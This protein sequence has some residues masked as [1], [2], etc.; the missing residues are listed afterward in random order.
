MINHFNLPNYIIDSILVRGAGKVTYKAKRISDGLVVA[1]ETVDALY[2]DR[3]LVASLRR[4]AS[5]SQ[6]LE[7]IDGVRKIHQVVSYGSGNI[8]LIGDL[9]DNSLAQLIIKHTGRTLPLSTALN[10]VYSVVETLNQVHRQ[11]IVHKALIPE[12]IFL[13]ETGDVALTGFNIASELDQERQTPQLS[14]QLVS[15]FPYMSPEQTGRMNRD[16]DYRSDYYSLGVLFYELLTGQ[17][18]FKANDTLGWVYNHVCH[19]PKSPQKLLPE[20][21]EV[22]ATIVMKLLEKS[23]EKRYQ[24]GFGLLHDIKCCVEQLNTKKSIAMFA[25]GEFDE[26]QKFLVPQKLYGREKESEQLLDLFEQVADG[27]T[28][29]CLVHGYSGVGKS[30]LV[31]E[32]DRYQVRERGF[33]VQSKFEQFQ[34]NEPYSALA[35]TYRALVQQ[36][37]SLPEHKLPYWRDK[38]LNALSPSASLLTAFV[39]ELELIIGKQPRVA[40]LP[41]DAARNRLHLTLA[42]FLIALAGEGHPVVLFLDDLHWS[43]IPTL[44]LLKR[45][46][47]SNKQ[48]HLLLIGAYRSNEVAAGHPLNNLLEELDKQQNIV[49]IPLRPLTFESV[50]QLV[51]D[52]LCCEVKKTLDL[53]ELLFNKAKGNPFFTNELLRQLHKQGVI[54]ATEGAR[55]WSYNIDAINWDNVS[56]NIIGFMLDNLRKLPSTSQEVLKLASCIGN[57]FDL[58]TLATIYQH[59]LADTAKVLL[60]ALKQYTVQPLHSDY[61]LVGDDQETTAFNPTYRFQHDKVQQ[62][63]YELIDESLLSQ[64]HLSIGQL[65]IANSGAVVPDKSISEIVGHLNK[66]HTLIQL[67]SERTSLAELN[68]RAAKRAIKGTAYDAGLKYLLA[69]KSLLPVKPWQ[70]MPEFMET[71]SSELQQ[72]YYHTG[73]FSSAELLIDKM[74]AHARS[75]IYR[76]NILA[77]RT[78]QYATVGRMEDSIIAAIQG[79]ALLNIQFTEQPTQADIDRERQDVLDNLAERK[80]VDLV[81]ADEVTEPDILIAM[82]LVMEIFPAAFLSGSGNLFPY[83]VLK[84]VNLSLRYGNCPESAFS[85]AAYGML[86]CGDLDEPALGYQYG[87]LALAINEKLDDLTLRS[88]VFYVYAMFIHHWS[89]HWSTLTPLFQKGIDAGYQSGDLL[90]LAYSAQDLVIWDPTLSLET[91]EYLHAKNLEIVRE[92]SYQ[93]S[94]DSGTLFL[95]LQR[96]FLGLTKSSLSLDDENFDGQACLAGMEQRQFLTG[97]AN[98]NIYNAEICFFYGDLQQA[99]SFVK[100]QD[101]LIKSAMSLPQLVR[102]YL[103]AN[104][105]LTTHY[106]NMDSDEQAETMQRL[107]IDLARMTR[108]AQNCESNFKHLEYLMS[109]E[110]ARIDGKVEQALGMYDLA[111]DFARKHEFLHDEAL[112]CERAACHLLTQGKER[113]AEGYLRA[114]YRLYDRRGAKRKVNWLLDT[115]P[116]LRELI[117]GNNTNDKE[118]ELLD[119]DLASVMKASRDISGEIV[120]DKLL[121]RSMSILLENS[122]AQWGCFIAKRNDDFIVEAL[123]MHEENKKLMV[124]PEHM[125]LQ[126]SE[127]GQLAL[128]IS[129]ISKAFYSNKTIILHDAIH[130]ESFKRDAYFVAQQ[131]RSVLCIPVKRE[132]FE[133]VLYLENNLLAGMFTNYRVEVIRLLTAQAL[134]AIE[135]ARLYEQ[136]QEYTHTLEAKVVERTARLEELNIELQNLVDLDGLTGIANRR[137]SDSYLQEVWLRSCRDELP[138]TVMMLDVD[139]FKSYNDNY[140]HQAGDACLKQVAKTMQDSLYR[141]DDLATRYGGEEFMIILPNT[142]PDGGMALADKIRTS[143]EKL[144]IEHHH[145]SAA[146]VVTIS[147]G[148]ATAIP[149]KSHNS[150]VEHLVHEADMALFK[151]K[152]FGRNQVCVAQ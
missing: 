138:V 8:A 15:V 58:Q 73:D 146:S 78:R 1:I 144:A 23:P 17:R 13:K 39:P 50:S 24:N 44:Q 137:R 54:V 67:E 83:L 84:S 145:S 149:T 60:P 18:P 71:L 63:A 22:V 62:A 140:G 88:R 75:D 103:T 110:L 147:V 143:V 115:Y 90:Y 133:G 111:I 117:A 9:Y 46:V 35:E 27:E 102:F 20:I 40:D 86:L 128:P 51:A 59:S 11:D 33:L 109:A 100:K 139:Q 92:C 119:L 52:S 141:V 64:V 65:M 142:Q 91:A 108:W 76:S 14:H 97:I 31:N 30:A 95:Q 49:N 34:Q 131:A 80:I 10:I 126:R 28:R 135:N 12:N 26:V 56:D 93:D 104:L 130:E 106:P 148:V 29:F 32:V 21:P 151:A 132:R 57:Y 101:K 69:A 87:K 70:Q 36:L 47:T 82:R 43:D 129:L 116:V 123:R 121:S 2:P 107:R 7:K 4:E 89:N 134:V 19:V 127:G 41:A 16:L 72:C 125:F 3:A 105:T 79:L 118:H 150:G 5:I 37:L 42:N 113:S 53:A 68:L 55:E 38:L 136:V 124:L 48:S 61:G 85:Y 45:I 66:S 96:N 94:L 98:Y 114:A 6:Q 122:G 81:D 99:L 25:L 152:Q 120:L 112:A 77:T 74:L